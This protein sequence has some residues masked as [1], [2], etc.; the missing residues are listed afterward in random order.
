MLN[1]RRLLKGALIAFLAFVVGG[2]ITALWPNPL[3]V[4][5]TPSGPVEIALLAAGAILLGVFTVVRRPVCSVRTA[6]AGSLMNF[7]GVACPVCNKL[8]VLALGAPFLMTYYEPWRLYFAAVGVVLLAISI[9]REIAAGR[10]E[11]PNVPRAG[12][13]NSD[14][15]IGGVSA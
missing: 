8:L 11:T 3:F 6:G 2:T 5:M 13:A 14:R 1:Q 4:R 12:S 9:A 7:L 10:G 15:G